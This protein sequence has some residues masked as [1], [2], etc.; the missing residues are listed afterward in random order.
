[1]AL[2]QWCRKF[3]DP[4]EK[5]G[6]SHSQPFLV[7]QT[8]S[9]TYAVAF[10]VYR[11]YM[12]VQLS[13]CH[14]Y[15]SSVSF[16][17][18]W[19]FPTL[20][21]ASHLLPFK[22]VYILMHARYIATPALPLYSAIKLPWVSFIARNAAQ[23]TPTSHFFIHCLM[24]R[25]S[26]TNPNEAKCSKKADRPSTCKK[27]P[28]GLNTY[29]CNMALNILASKESG[30]NESKPRWCCTVWCSKCHCKQNEAHTSMV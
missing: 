29:T 5:Q 20:S 22:T 13:V 7:R 12:E 2:N 1:M 30:D 21:W 16:W 10:L 25:R 27:R 6:F 23:T 24:T 9:F 8:S 14:M 18:L 3:F 26:Q 28:P 11:L 4:T 15:F 19:F 17:T